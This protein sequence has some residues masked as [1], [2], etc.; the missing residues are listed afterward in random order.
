M[1]TRNW[2]GSIPRICMLSAALLVGCSGDDYDDGPQG[3]VVTGNVKSVITDAVQAARP[4]TV[5]NLADFSGPAV[6]SGTSDSNGNYSFTVN[7]PLYLV[8]L[9][10]A[11]TAPTSDPGISGLS[12]VAEGNDNKPLDDVTSLACA[13]GVTAVSEGT[14]QPSEM[15]RLRI[16]YLEDAA[17][18]V[19]AEDDPDFTNSAEFNAAVER[20]RDLTDDGDHPPA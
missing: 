1:A 9:F 19:I 6:A 13:A 20:V 4:F 5:K 12:S 7:G 11:Q 8:I 10:A 18:Q 16:S 3:K 2:L 15:N 14:V 17:E